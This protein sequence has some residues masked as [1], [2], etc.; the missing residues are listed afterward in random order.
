MS[1]TIS[2]RQQKVDEKKFGENY[3]KIFRKDKKKKKIKSTLRHPVSAGN[4]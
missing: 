2:N 3:D 4:V 1:K